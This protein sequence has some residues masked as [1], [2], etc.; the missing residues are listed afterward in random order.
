[1]AETTLSSLRLS[2][3]WI[4]QL[5][6]VFVEVVVAAIA[7]I[8]FLIVGARGGAWILGGIAA[9]AIVFYGYR[10][11]FFQD[12]GPNRDLRKL[13]Q[14]LIGL[15]VGFS[16]QNLNLSQLS[17]QIPVLMAIAFFLLFNG[18]WIGYLYARLE[19]TDLLTAVLATFPGNIGVVAS[20]AADYE[21][22]TA[23]VSL[24]QLLRFTSI[25][26]VVPLV[27]S[28]PAS[29][30][31]SSTLYAL[32]ADFRTV[33]LTQML[34]LGGSLCLA[35]LTVMAGTRLKIPVASFICS[36][37][38]GIVL[39]Q[40]VLPLTAQTFHLPQVLKVIG[41]I[42]LGIT[43]GEY[44]AIHPSLQLKTIWRAL[45][46]VGLT[47]LTALLAAAI[48]RSL[49]HWDWLT[50]L[51]VAAPG[52]SPEMIWIALALNH[53]IELVTTG[54]II[55]LL[56]INL[57]LPLVITL[58]VRLEQRWQFWRQTMPTNG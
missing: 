8:G 21:R 58:T 51:L 2:P 17:F 1:M 40:L 30:A 34:W 19:Q 56:T 55:R 53:N 9:G 52:G 26:L 42:F 49:T 25:I 20:V 24:V 13:G 36:I 10:Q 23:L 3:G 46:P 7:G 4:T 57:A 6:L 29:Q 32:I 16:V 28:V 43:I 18:G 54:H 33:D 45:L 14:V 39:T 31:I 12:Q 11:W 47:C 37:G 5:A 41:Q 15:T 35:S 38:T 48:A 44:W 22:N 27:A 50:C